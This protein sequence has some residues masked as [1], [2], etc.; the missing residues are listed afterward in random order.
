MSTVLIVCSRSVCRKQRLAEPQ[1][2]EKMASLPDTNFLF[3]LAHSLC[4]RIF[5]FQ[6]VKAQK[7]IPCLRSLLGTSPIM[8]V[9]LKKIIGRVLIRTACLPIRHKL[10]PQLQDCPLN[11]RKATPYYEL[12]RLMIASHRNELLFKMIFVFSNS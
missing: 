8:Q 12:Y 10:P 6:F 2:R 3:S 4:S 5:D 7:I 9:N 1:R 11:V